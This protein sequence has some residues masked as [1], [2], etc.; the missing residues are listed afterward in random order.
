[1]FGSR[2]FAVGVVLLGAI[3]DVN[4]YAII[5]PS[6]EPLLS[7]CELVLSSN[8]F[9]TV[10]QF[11]MADIGEPESFIGVLLALYGNH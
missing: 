4:S 8:H 11:I 3:T 1:M 7:Y 2:E 5:I 9:N 6:E 10:I